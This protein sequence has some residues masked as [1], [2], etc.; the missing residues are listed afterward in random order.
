MLAV[1]DCKSSA[2]TLY[3]LFSDCL[4][5]YFMFLLRSQSWKITF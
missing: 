2:L 4:F 5:S 3:H 1:N